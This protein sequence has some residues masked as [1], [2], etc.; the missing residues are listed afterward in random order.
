MAVVLGDQSRRNKLNV[1]DVETAAETRGIGLAGSDVR[2]LPES[3]GDRD[4]ARSDSAVVSDGE[5]EHK[6]EYKGVGALHPCCRHPVRLA[7]KELQSVVV[8]VVRIVT[9]TS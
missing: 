8:Q 7:E 1:F 9:V 6:V 4:L 5:G 3:E 2:V